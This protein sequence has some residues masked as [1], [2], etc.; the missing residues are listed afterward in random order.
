MAWIVAALLD[1][2]GEQVWATPDWLIAVGVL[3]VVS[4]WFFDPKAVFRRYWKDTGTT[5]MDTVK[6]E[7]QVSACRK[8]GEWSFLLQGITKTGQSLDIVCEE[9][10]IHRYLKRETGIGPAERVFL[11]GVT[12]AIALAQKAGGGIL[13]KPQGYERVLE[14]KSARSRSISADVKRF[15]WERDEGACSI[16]GVTADL[17][18]DHIL[19]F[20]KGGANTVENIQ[21]LCSICNLAKG[22]KIE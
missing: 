19:P 22:A 2:A 18:Y 17:H 5:L 6:D 10:G 14:R 7:Y 1:R 15:V 13:V 12:E 16:C 8:C 3:T 4:V 11:S 20:S 9:C 21:I